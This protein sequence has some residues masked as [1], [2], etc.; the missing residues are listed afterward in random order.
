MTQ[1]LWINKDSSGR[2]RYQLGINE[3]L[4]ALSSE[5]DV[6][7]GFFQDK[8]TLEQLPGVQS[9]SYDSRREGGV[10]YC[11]VDVSVKHFSDLVQLQTHVMKDSLP[12]R[13]QAEYHTSMELADQEDGTGAFRFY[14]ENRA[15]SANN[16][17]LQR[18]ADHFADVLMAQVMSGR[19]W[20]VTLHTDKILNTNGE[21]LEQGEV[22]QWKVP[23]YDLMMDMN[24][25]KEMQAEFDLNWPWYK[26][27]WK[28][29]S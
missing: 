13:Y 23:L 16:D 8:T 7:A 6:C 24:Y 3:Q 9:V 2:M 12:A 28:W 26:R 10:Q 1:D 14:I 27:L 29:V 4:A 18:H 21:Q 15:R 11:I 22:I 25:A 17:Q 19:Y 5:Q 20:T